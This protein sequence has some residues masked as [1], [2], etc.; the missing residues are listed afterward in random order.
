ML[1]QQK[2]PAGILAM[3]PM[4]IASRGGQF[5]AVALSNRKL[6]IFD[7]KYIVDWV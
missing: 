5:V 1:W 6:L 2:M 3:Q 4:D 7:D